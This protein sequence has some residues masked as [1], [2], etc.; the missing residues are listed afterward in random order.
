MLLIIGT[1]KVKTQHRNQMEKA[2]LLKSWLIKPSGW[3]VGGQLS[4]TFCGSMVAESQSNVFPQDS[5]WPC[6]VPQKAGVI[7]L[8]HASS[9]LVL[10]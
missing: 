5:T 7:W 3:W 9:E 4:R 10:G 8:P 2:D 6:F 1:K